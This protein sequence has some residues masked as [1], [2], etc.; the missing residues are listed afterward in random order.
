MVP[1]FKKVKE[2]T[3]TRIYEKG[4]LMERLLLLSESYM[5]EYIIVVLHILPGERD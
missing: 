5:C 2:K 4:C 1:I 3:P